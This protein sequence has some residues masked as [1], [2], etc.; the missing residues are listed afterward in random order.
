[1]PETVMK[2]GR[3]VTQPTLAE[4]LS[5]SLQGAMAAM[6][7]MQKMKQAKQDRIDEAK[8]HADTLKTTLTQLATDHP[9]LSTLAAAS[10]A[11]SLNPAL[12][13]LKEH[14][15]EG[16]IPKLMHRKEHQALK[17]EAAAFKPPTY[18]VSP[19]LA[20]T[21]AKA[22]ADAAKA[23]TESDFS[24][25][26]KGA[27]MK[28]AEE[29]PDDVVA[30]MMLEQQPVNTES[31]A[32]RTDP[33]GVMARLRTSQPYTKEWI[34]EKAAGVV[35]TLKG[36]FPDVDGVT[37]QV[38]SH[39]AFDPNFKRPPGFK[40]PLSMSAQEK[41]IQRRANEL[42]AG[43]LG[44]QTKK[45]K[46]ETAIA[47]GAF[48]QFLMANSD[49]P[50]GIT[51]EVAMDQARKYMAGKNMDIELPPDKMKEAQRLLT[52]AQGNKMN[53][54]IEQAKEKSATFDQLITLAQH[55]K[56]PDKQQQFMDKAYTEFKKIHG[57]TGTP[58]PST[59]AMFYIALMKGVTPIVGP[60][61]AAMVAAYG[62]PL[63]TK[64]GAMT[65]GAGR[66]GVSGAVN[67]LDAIAGSGQPA[68]TPNIEKVLRGGKPAGPSLDIAAAYGAQVESQVK[69]HG[70]ALAKQMMDPAT[71]EDTKAM[72]RAH[73]QELLDALQ[74]KDYGAIMRLL[75]AGKPMSEIPTPDGGVR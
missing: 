61:G 37:L 23:K 70:D 17:D 74:K 59:K 30:Q 29:N 6:M 2:N 22:A 72:I 33:Q 14:E 44:L 8:K 27:I 1:M 53:L 18:A 64:A 63:A 11:D 3:L 56:D 47:T 41:A 32:L 43:E 66:A 24:A 25:A 54:D 51:S 36:E 34:E 55:E 13:K 67:T 49:N 71:S 69:A 9:E 39:E 20:S 58:P 21:R 5:E 52:V 38:L 10:V 26:S 46:Q 75:Q 68:L 31:Y 62:V 35:N 73:T 60:E 15:G 12:L 57:I 45:F 48:A 28:R 40:V 50:E 19:E 65:V 42:R 16:F 7:Q 4:Q